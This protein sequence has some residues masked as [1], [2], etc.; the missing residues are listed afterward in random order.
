MSKQF[1][2]DRGFLTFAVG[3][4]YL[5]L[6]RAQA[7][8]VKLTQ[9]NI[10]NFAVV[11]DKTASL[12]ILEDDASMFDKIIVIDHTA[13]GWDMSCEWMA[14][15]LTPWKETIKTDA[16]MLFSAP[17]DHWF[18]SL[19]YRDVA[20]A[21]SVVDFRGGKITSRTHRQLFDLNNLPNVYSALTYFR[22]SHGASNFFRT[23]KQ[24]TNDWD[25]YAKELL[26]RNDDPRPR[27]DEIFALAAMQLGKEKFLFPTSDILTFVH[28]KEMLN[29]LE[30]AV[31][32]Y[33]QIYSYWKR[34]KLF[35]GN[36]AQMLPFHY[37][38][39]GWMN[40]EQYNSIR[41]DYQ[42]FYRSN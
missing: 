9:T 42:E 34:D 41:R 26:V 40:D 27:T 1:I 20:I 39:K 4:D 35:V 32:W 11:V 2:S 33:N 6:A 15:N 36:I 12:H 30:T 13:D 28:M 8:S 21:N 37:H 24:I 3:K 10:K 31:P 29:D 16:D 25:W 14:F 38:Q 19:Q 23:V 5:K 18:T 7:M 17:V 22:H